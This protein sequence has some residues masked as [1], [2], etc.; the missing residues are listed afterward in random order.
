MSYW[1]LAVVQKRPLIF[2]IRWHRVFESTSGSLLALTFGASAT[3]GG[4]R[5]AAER[6]VRGAAETDWT[7]RTLCQRWQ[8]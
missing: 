7:T 4:L 2:P 8:K 1:Y 6:P 3:V 5:H